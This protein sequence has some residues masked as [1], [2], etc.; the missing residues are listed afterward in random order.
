[1][2]DATVSGNTFTGNTGATA[3]AG[4]CGGVAIYTDVYSG[5]PSVSFTGNTVQD[6]VGGTAAAGGGGGGLCASGKVQVS[7][8]NILDNTAATAGGGSGG[9]VMVG[10]GLRGASL[11][12]PTTLSGNTVRGNVASASGDGQGGGLYVA[13]NTM[14]STDIFTVTHNL[15][16]DNVASQ[17]GAGTGG[18]VYLG[19]SYAARLDA[20][21]ILGNFASKNA[22]MTGLGGGL[23]I[24][25]S[26]AFSVTNSVIARNRADTQGSGV[27]MG[28][29]GNLSEPFTWGRFVHT[30]IADNQ[31]GAGVWLES[32]LYAGTLVDP[33]TSGTQ[34]KV[35]TPCFYRVGD[36]LLI[37]HTNGTTRAWRKLVAVLYGDAWRLTIDSPLPGA[38]PVGS[39][40][41]DASAM[42]VNTI[43][44]GQTTG[45]GAKDQP[46]TLVHTLWNGNGANT[47]DNLNAI[48]TQGDVSGAP[49]F[50]N[51]GGGDYHIGSASAARDTGARCGH[52]RRH[53]RRHPAIRPRLRHWRG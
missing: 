29:T 28:K 22:G 36:T 44:A 41:R 26:N 9:G 38:F 19:P 15:I 12:G 21:T 6:N 20:N 10:L 14:N 35:T 39:I 33:Y 17:S 32:P 25:S 34:L 11:G 51:S 23:A 1:M 49:A 3:Q 40:V 43:I 52:P 31:V 4:Y 42:F 50:L 7:E 48:L 27:W 37:L 18:G 45:L 47:S 46:V 30:T 8:N 53:G 16:A 5:G 13:R 2:A 24:A